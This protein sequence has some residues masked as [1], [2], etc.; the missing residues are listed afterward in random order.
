M[1]VALR[2]GIYT[3]L[4]STGLDVLLR[5][6]LGGVGVIL[7]F[8]RVL[9]APPDIH[10]GPSQ[11]LIVTAEAFQAAIAFLRN[12]GYDIVSLDEVRRRLL[13]RGKQKKFACLTFDDG[14]IDNYEVVYPICQK[15]EVPIAIYITINM[16][17]A[18]ILLWWFGLER[19]IEQ[20][21]FVQSP[22]NGDLRIYPCRSTAEK[23][24]SYRALDRL[25]RHASEADRLRMIEKLERESGVDFKAVSQGL[26]MTWPMVKELSRSGRVTIGAHTITHRALCS[27]GEDEMR[28]E[29]GESRD[30]LEERLAIRIKHFAY[31]F[32]RSSDASIRE[33]EICKSLGF[34]TATTTRPGTLKRGHRNSLHSLPRINVLNE[35]T[36]Q[37]LRADLTNVPA[38]F[39][40]VFFYVKG[41]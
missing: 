6:M 21:D 24:S 15:L 41:L 2:N 3:A 9:L 35:R 10:H 27:L 29:I 36:V 20:M 14:Y 5:P 32:G 40:T 17:E 13:A 8:H 28:R 7:T 1:P 33:Y 39:K 25:L 11:S 23:L 34:D 30:I 4:G 19:V 38:V 18:K 16:I 22:A 37:T 31:P 26:A 12:A